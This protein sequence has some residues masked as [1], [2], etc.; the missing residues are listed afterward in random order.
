MIGHTRGTV[1]VYQEAIWDRQWE[2]PL[3][4]FSLARSEWELGKKA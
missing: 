2:L 1:L 4:E 3:V